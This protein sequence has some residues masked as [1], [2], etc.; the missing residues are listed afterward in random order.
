MPFRVT[1]STSCACEDVATVARELPDFRV[2][3]SAG[4]VFEFDISLLL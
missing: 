3:S 1:A 2:C 4:A